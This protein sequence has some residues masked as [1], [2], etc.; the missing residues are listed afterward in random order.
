[1]IFLNAEATLMKLK[2]GSQR[3]ISP[4]A[5]MEMESED[6]C[7][8][9]VIPK[10]CADDHSSHHAEGTSQLVSS[11]EEM[12]MMTD[13]DCSSTS[14]LTGSSDIQSTGSMEQQQSRNMSIQYLF[15]KFKSSGQAKRLSQEEIMIAENSD[16]SASISSNS[17]DYM[18]KMKEQFEQDC[19]SSF[20]STQI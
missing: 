4:S 15:S 11:N 10:D 9:S 17:N 18:R 13:T 14:I 16:S 6:D 5:A 3:D 19:F 20:T 7:V 1:M 12:L 8:S 2:H